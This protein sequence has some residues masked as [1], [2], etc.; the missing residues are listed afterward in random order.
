MCISHDQSTGKNYSFRKFN[1]YRIDDLIYHNNGSTAF[2]GESVIGGN[3]NSRNY[4]FS[5]RHGPII[6]LPWMLRTGLK[7][8]QTKRFR[9]HLLRAGFQTLSAFGFFL[10]LAVIPLATVTALHFTTP[11]FAVV[12]SI[13][14]LGELVSVH[15][16]TAI[17]VGF[18]GVIIILRPGFIGIGYGEMLILFSAIAWAAAIIIIKVVSRTDS[19]ITTTAYMYVLMTPT[20]FI[21]ALWDWSW[22]NPEQ[23][24]W[25]IAIG[26]T[27][28][29]GHVFVAEAFKRGDTHVVFPFDYFRL[30]WATFIGVFWFGDPPDAFVWAGGGLIISS[31]SY[32]AWREHKLGAR[33]KH[34]NRKI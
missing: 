6:F 9:L 12:F 13:I 31:S 25:L 22:P 4:F 1:W 23:Y 5:N 34:S 8:F 21:A 11:I 15:R 28:A 19:S 7:I 10:G 32:I 29:L 17:I 14:L 24:I 2:Y 20:T 16:W 3:F 18:T 27:G 33:R 30:I 26:L